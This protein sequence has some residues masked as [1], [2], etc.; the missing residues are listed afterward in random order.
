MDPPSFNEVRAELAGANAYQIEYECVFGRSHGGRCLNLIEQTQLRRA[1]EL[2]GIP[3]QHL[4]R[5][6]IWNIVTCLVCEAHQADR[7]YGP[8]HAVEASWQRELPHINFSLRRPPSPNSFCSSRS[9][10]PQRRRQTGAT[11]P[12]APSMPWTPQRPPPSTTASDSRTFLTP[13]N[14][15]L[16]ATGHERSSSAPDIFVQ[17]PHETTAEENERSTDE[18]SSE[19][20]VDSSA[21]D[22]AESV[23]TPETELSSISTIAPESPSQQRQRRRMAIPG[24]SSAAQEGFVEGEA[25]S[26]APWTI[27]S[28]VRSLM[29]QPLPKPRDKG[30]IYVVQHI[31]SQHVKIGI[32]M[33]SFRDRLQELSRDHQCKFDERSSYHLPGIPYIQLLRLEKLVHSDLAYFRRNL[34]V[35]NGGTFRTY[36]E[37]FAVDI[38]TAQRTVSLWWEIMCKTRMEPG[39]E[40]NADIH[41]QLTSSTAFDVEI[42][43]AADRAHSWAQANSDHGARLQ[44]WTD[45][46]LSTGNTCNEAFSWTWWLTGCVCIWV[47]LQ[48]LG[49]PSQ[50]ANVGCLVLAAWPNKR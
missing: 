11:M 15:D 41:D 24:T 1:I 36:T 7:N 20:S 2:L 13:P 9:P 12:L 23:Q 30:C 34:R 16:Q 50:V 17:G 29:L 27:R 39:C 31:D 43:D 42:V 3:Q 46:L 45:L 8:K 4:D 49:V 35:R 37:W 25:T 48:A 40:L 44:L 5:K 28:E 33:R 6:N 22:T 19:I 14:L 18:S 47:V 32:T 38:G 21:P 10:T 26:W